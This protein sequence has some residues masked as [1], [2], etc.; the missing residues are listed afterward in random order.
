MALDLVRVADVVVENFRPGVMARMGLDYAAARRRAP[1]PRVLLDLG[2]RPDGA[3]A[4]SRRLSPTSCTPTSGLMHLERGRDG[5]AASPVSPGRRHPGRHPRV[6]R[7]LGRAAPPGPHRTRRATWT[8]RCSRRSS[9]AE[10]I[11]FGS[12]LNDGA[13]V[14]RTAERDARAPGRRQLG[15]APDGRRARSLAAAPRAPGPA[16]PRPRTRASPRPWPGA[17][18]GPSSVRSSRPGSTASP[19]PTRRSP[20]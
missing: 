8:C 1:G 18:T 5:A 9:A 7:H 15:G 17:T 3:V 2:L 16:G 20:P 14:P 13:D 6:R 12:V 4:G 19:S 10:D 11:S